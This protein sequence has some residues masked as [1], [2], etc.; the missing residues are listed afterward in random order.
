MNVVLPFPNHKKI[1]EKERNL[2][3]QKCK[4]ET[5]VYRNVSSISERCLQ[6]NVYGVF[7]S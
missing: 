5:F 1:I 7:A 6:K 3:V 2:D 4:Y